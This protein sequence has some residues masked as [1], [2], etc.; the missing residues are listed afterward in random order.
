MTY[1]RQKARPPNVH[2]IW[3]NAM[4]NTLAQAQA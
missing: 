1:R 2:V 3:A 4:K